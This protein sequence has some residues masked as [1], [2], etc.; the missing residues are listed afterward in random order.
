MS[1]PTGF[2]QQIAQAKTEEEAH[3][4]VQQANAVCSQAS[5]KTKKAWLHTYERRVRE[6]SAVN[7]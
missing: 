6:L 4:L 5:E 3:L 7:G 2:R 1:N